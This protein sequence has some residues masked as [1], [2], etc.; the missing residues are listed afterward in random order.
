KAV[1]SQQQHRQVMIPMIRCMNWLCCS[2]E[3]RCLGAAVHVSNAWKIPYSSNSS[4]LVARAT[5][6]PTGAASGVRELPRQRLLRLLLV[7][8]TL[9][10]C[11]HMLPMSWMPTRFS[12][13]VCS[14]LSQWFG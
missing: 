2:R 3:L 6:A 5:E 1:C 12:A 11:L 14:T 4:T 8:V 7:P 10:A 9:V 13:E